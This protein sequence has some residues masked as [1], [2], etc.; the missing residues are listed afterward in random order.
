MVCREAD[1]DAALADDIVL[2]ALN[3]KIPNE[4]ANNDDVELVITANILSRPV[5]FNAAPEA[6][7]KAFAKKTP[8]ISTCNAG[9]DLAL[10]ND[11]AN[12][13]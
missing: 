10:L 2:V 6:L 5:N 7:A 13:L 1:A 3:A 4:R 8:G 12:V 9:D 11:L